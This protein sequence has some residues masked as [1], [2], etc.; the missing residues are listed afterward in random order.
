MIAFIITAA[1]CPVTLCALPTRGLH[2]LP[3]AIQRP[4]KLYLLISLSGAVT[5]F[6]RLMPK[7]WPSV[8]NRSLASF[9]LYL[10]PK[11]SWKQCLCL[12]IT[13][14][15]NSVTGNRTKKTKPY[16]SYIHFFYSSF[17]LVLLGNRHICFL[18]KHYWSHSHMCMLYRL[19]DCK[20]WEKMDMQQAWSCLQKS[21]C[22]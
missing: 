1:E 10:L 2:R 11:L 6:S 5:L 17:T 16:A 19:A 3:P 18:M 22:N 14:I 9:V 12:T 20:E 21:T 13:Q 4:L 7:E 8:L 15:K